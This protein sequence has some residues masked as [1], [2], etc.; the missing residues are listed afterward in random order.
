LLLG[1]AC[2]GGAQ[3]LLLAAFARVDAATLAPLNYFQLLLAV[4]ISTFW[5]QRRPTDLRWP[6]SALILAAGIYLACVRQP[7][8]RQRLGSGAPAIT[9]SIHEETS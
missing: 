4:L 6:A 3:W 2:S 9:T 8:A 5:F 1:G 7:P